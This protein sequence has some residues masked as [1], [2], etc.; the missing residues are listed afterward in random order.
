MYMAYTTNP[1]LPRV[2]GEAVALLQK[3]WSTR[4][5]ARHLG[6]SQSAI[7]KWHAR[8]RPFG[9][10]PIP[11]RSSRPKSH[12]HTLPV[13]LTDEIAGTRLRLKRS[14]E[15]VH[16]DLRRRGVA[17]SLSS[18]KRTLDRQYLLKKRSPWKRYHAPTARPEAT[19]P[20]A[21]LQADT[22]HLAINGRT[23]LY[24][25]TIIDVYSRWVYALTYAKANARIALSFVKR[26]QTV[27]PFMFD[28]IQTDNGPEWS[29][30]FTE[31]LK[32]RHRHS[33]VR[34][35]NDNAHVE[36]F[37]RTIQ[38]ECTDHLPVDLP[39]INRALPAY[40]SYYNEKRLH[41]GLK[42]QTPLEILTKLTKVIPSY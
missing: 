26:A 6:F 34:Q 9:Y 13:A 14:S 27:A 41:F 19:A 18:V 8:G 24:V 3:G 17:V 1:H 10:G 23:V 36:R 37:N 20:G 32:I 22:I 39:A 21:L 38:E 2:R 33:R 25:F 31:R 15:V 29:T 5:V 12:P 42:L 11:T 28:C 7:V 16:E 40:L 4:K 30:H 35:S